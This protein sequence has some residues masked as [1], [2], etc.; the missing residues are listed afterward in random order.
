MYQDI[1]VPYKRCFTCNITLLKRKGVR[2]FCK[3]F[4]SIDNLLLVKLKAYRFTLAMTLMPSYI[5]L[6]TGEGAGEGG[7]LA[8]QT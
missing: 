8:I 2:V 3:A 5:Y 4:D 7:S 1:H 6:A